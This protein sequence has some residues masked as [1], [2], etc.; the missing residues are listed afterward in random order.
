MVNVHFGMAKCTIHFRMMPPYL[1]RGICNLHMF[2]L[3]DCF[4][5]AVL[6]I[7]KRK[8]VSVSNITCRV[9]GSGPHCRTKK[10]KK[11]LTYLMYVYRNNM[12][13]KLDFMT[14]LLH[15]HVQYFLSYIYAGYIFICSYA[16]MDSYIHA[17]IRL[18]ARPYTGGY[19]QQ[20]H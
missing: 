13:A 14:S 20:R 5:Y 11:K 12:W 17:N 3:L 4:K 10:K 9:S 7:H 19:I 15:P 6:C 8:C 2:A 18:W 1:C 16:C